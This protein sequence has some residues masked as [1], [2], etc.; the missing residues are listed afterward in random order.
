MEGAQ[1]LALKLSSPKYEMLHGVEADCAQ[2]QGLLH[3]G[4]QI[5]YPVFAK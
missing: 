5:T 1:I 3:S 2:H 4:M